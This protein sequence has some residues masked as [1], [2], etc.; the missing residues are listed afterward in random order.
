MVP[1]NAGG[2]HEACKGKGSCGFQWSWANRDRCFRCNRAFDGLP[3]VA[4]P[5]PLA[6]AWAR[7][8]QKPKFEK[9]TS[10]SPHKE[11]KETDDV[12]SLTKALETLKQVYSAQDPLVTAVAEKLETAKADKINGKPVWM[13]YQRLEQN[14]A[15]K[16]KALETTTKKITDIQ[17]QI[18]KLQADAQEAEGFKAGLEVE[19]EALAKE[20]SLA[21][22]DKADG[23]VHG[24]DQIPAEY[25]EGEAWK[26]AQANLDQALKAMQD[27]VSEHKPEEPKP[28]SEAE[29][30][31]QHPPT[32]GEETDIDMW[33]DD[34][35]AVLDDVFADVSLDLSDDLR[36]ELKR[37][38]NAAVDG[39][40]KSRKHLLKAK[41]LRG[42]VG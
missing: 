15:R 32:A 14:L 19:I 29:Q 28:P 10:E 37:K 41:Q 6:G 40:I 13:Q 7:P 11:N 30:A 1:P 18:E 35:K 27:L 33:D 36:T 17:D 38:A 42:S 12:A 16:Q 22:R 34:S 8:W 39:A 5:P 3:Q 9:W 25:K 21:P 4:H 24:A 20:I 26:Q 23:M 31:S 2:S